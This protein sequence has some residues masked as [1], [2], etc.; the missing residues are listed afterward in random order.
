MLLFP[1]RQDIKVHKK[2]QVRKLE[3]ARRAH[4][5]ISKIGVSS[6][7]NLPNLL[8]PVGLTMR[9]AV[10][11]HDPAAPKALGSLAHIEHQRLLQ[12]DG[13][14]SLNAHHPICSRRF[15][16]ARRRDPVW[17]VTIAVLAVSWNIEEPLLV[18]N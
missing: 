13:A 6:R 16:V 3:I 17:A 9:E 15:P 4:R 1:R 12:P 18:P 2:F 7:W 10:L 5:N 8:V 14:V 11:V